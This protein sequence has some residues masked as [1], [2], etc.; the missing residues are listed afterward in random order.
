MNNQVHIVGAGGHTRSLINLLTSNDYIIN[1]I[2]DNN[3]DEQ[4]NETIMSSRLIG[5][6]SNIGIND[7]LVLSFGDNSIREKHFHQLK[8]QLVSKN[9]LH[10]KA[11]IE[12][13]FKSGISNQ[14]FANVYIN[15]NV[16]IGDNNII[17]TGAIIE[18]E[19]EIKS[20]NHISVGSIICGRVKIGNNCFIGA[21]STVI[22]K[23]S[24]CDNVIIGAN[25]VVIKEID[26]P[27]TYVGNPV[28]R[29]K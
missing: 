26:M 20:H 24:I 14:I 27:G 16:V 12:S 9:L 28:R 7:L 25:S 5:K 4:N 1:G 3:Y 23:I 15:S 21:G 22:D 17:N 11:L 18:H 8:N 6:I 2:Y 13:H 19:V 29:I 10:Y